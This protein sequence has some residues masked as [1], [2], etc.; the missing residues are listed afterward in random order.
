MNK[1]S[2]LLELALLFLLSAAAGVTQAAPSNAPIDAFVEQQL[3]RHRLPG[4]A[5]VITQGRQVIYQ[6]GYGQANDRTPVTPQTQFY[7][8]STSKSF[9]ALAVLQLVEASRIDLDA[10][11]QRYL[12]EFATRDAEAAGQVTVRQLLNQ[13]GGL[14]DSGFAETSLPQMKSPAERLA[15]LRS[16][17]PVARPG[18]EFHYFNPNYEVLARL[19]E[20]ASG[21]SF[22]AYLQ[23]HVFAPLGMRDTSNVIHSTETADKA[24][25]LAQGHI[26]PYGVPWPADEM[27]GYMG[28][29]GGVVST[30]ADLAN[31]LI[32]QSQQGRFGEQALV[33]PASMALM[34]TPPS[35]IE[36][37][38]G[39][40]WFVRVENGQRI[41]EHNGI[42]SA[43]YAETVLLPEKEIGLALLYNASSLPAT[44]FA[45]PQVKDGLI[46]LLSDR[47]PETGG[48]TVAHW[49]ILFGLLT[50]GGIGLAVRSLLGLPRWLRRPEKGPG[51]RLALRILWAFAP[52]LLL[53]GVPSLV[54]TSSGRAFGYA[55]LLRSM[56]EVFVWLGTY[57]VLELANGI[58]R[59]GWAIDNVLR[60]RKR[61]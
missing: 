10:P 21:Q 14:A 22:S 51:W 40:G 42:F 50:L 1:T 3:A 58:V 11:V 45:F 37:S 30:A 59:L 6:K 36:T 12:P 56:P 23:D 52:A 28:G 41:L 34:Q 35:G 31:F 13:T 24:A 20:V 57:A 26:Q 39:M 25:R 38:Y 4:M 2:A 46:A 16:A 27:A 53:L 49:G 8:A 60:L 33:S 55:A 15:S 54:L 29:S 17:R 19:V 18:R 43:F 9:T 7:L 47:Q 61:Q 32:M 48:F 44:L 5:L